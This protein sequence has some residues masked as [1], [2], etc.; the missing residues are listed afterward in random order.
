MKK[1]VIA[2]VTLVVVVIV[3]Y[4]TLSGSKETP[5]KT[6]DVAMG[7]INE[8][9]IAVG[10]IVPKH[11][12]TVKSQLSGIVDTVLHESGDYVHKGDVL[13][14]VKPNPTP[15]QYANAVS[16]VKEDQADVEAMLAKLENYQGLV[17]SK[18]VTENYQELV[19]LKGELAHAQAKLEYDEQSLALLTKGSATIAGENI[20]S[21]VVSP[22]DGFIL[23]RNVDVGDPVI[24]LASSQTATI[25]FTIANMDDLIFKGSVDE[26]DA[27]KLKLAMPAVVE[28]AA[29]P[30]EKIKG[31]LTQL[32]L[33][34]QQSS[35]DGAETTSPF[36]VGFQVEVSQLDFP[37]DVILRSGYSA[38]AKIVVKT[39]SDVLVIPESAVL[40]RE[41]NAFVQLPAKKGEEA[42]QIKIVT[43]LSDG[44][45]IEVK[46]GLALGDT[47]IRSPVVTPQRS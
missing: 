47:I 40:F 37:D 28:V 1:S 6:V 34:S 3:A 9:S 19:I 7:T 26:I 5:A 17:E 20:E 35:V 32:S 18:N 23:E 27:G 4:W 39:V 10:E 16:L 22:V 25:L 41:H 46:E 33:Q 8:E 21:T 14:Q 31:L 2:L 15:D 13:L 44:I 12:I 36:N 30:D 29:L 24:S 38:T 11:S 45:H 42:T 43:G